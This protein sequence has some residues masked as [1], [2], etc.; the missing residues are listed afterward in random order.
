[1]DCSIPDAIKAYQRALISAEVGDTDTAMRIG[2]LYSLLGD[3]TKAAQYHRRALQEGIKGGQSKAELSKT[4]L[5]A[6]FRFAFVVVEAM[7]EAHATAV[8]L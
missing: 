3:S 6:W 4:Y 7:E 1:M 5:C 2:R 8:R